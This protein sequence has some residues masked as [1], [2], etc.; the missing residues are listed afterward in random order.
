MKVKGINKKIMGIMLSVFVVANVFSLPR[1]AMADDENS[2]VKYD[3]ITDVEMTIEAEN[4]L[5]DGS[6]MPAYVPNQIVMMDDLLPIGDGLDSVIGDDDRIELTETEASTYPYSAI[7]LI[8]A[9]YDT[10]NDDIADAYYRGTGTMVGPRTILTAAHL[11]WDENN[12][13]LKECEIYP[14]VSGGTL[15]GNDC[16]SS[17]IF[18]VPSNYQNGINTQKNDWGIIELPESCDL[19]DITGYMGGCALSFPFPDLGL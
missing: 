3:S 2:F 14:C 19:A 12:H 4:S 17:N 18:Y 7:V 1:T 10:D 9:G 16:Y 15:I 11:L 5:S 6:T 8:I 13:W